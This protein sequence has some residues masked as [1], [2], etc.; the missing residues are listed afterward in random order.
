MFNKLLFISGL[1]SLSKRTLCV[2]IALVKV[3]LKRTVVNT[4]NQLSNIALCFVT[5]LVKVLLSRT[6]VVNI[7]LTYNYL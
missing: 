5:A 7:L 6:R 3:L 4:F 1:N 2:V